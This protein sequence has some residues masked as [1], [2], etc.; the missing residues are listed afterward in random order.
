MY[1]RRIKNVYRVA[2]VVLV[3][4]GIT[5]IGVL[6]TYTNTRSTNLERVKLGEQNN[7]L[8]KEVQAQTKLLTD[9]LTPG[10]ACARRSAQNTGDFGAA[11]IVCGNDPTIIT[12]DQ[13]LACVLRNYHPTPPR[14]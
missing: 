4:V 8:L 9:C 13:A 10:G 2:L 3:L 1:R 12:K 14:G 7:V 5:V 11:I 6:A